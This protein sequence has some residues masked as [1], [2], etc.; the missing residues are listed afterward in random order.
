MKS[1]YQITKSWIKNHRMILLV[2]ITLLITYLHK[3]AGF[4]FQQMMI[5]K[6]LVFLYNLNYILLIHYKSF[7]IWSGMEAYA[8]NP[9]SLWDQS[10][11]NCLKPGVQTSLGNK[12]RPS[13]YKK[14]FKNSLGI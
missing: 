8:Y 2:W 4:I 6:W 3:K 13:L 9:N 5:M 1:H 11:E 12:A 7:T 10:G 14:I